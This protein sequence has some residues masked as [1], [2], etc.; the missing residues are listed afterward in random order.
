MVGFLHHQPRNQKGN[1]Q[2][3]LILHFKWRFDE[4]RNQSQPRQYRLFKASPKFIAGVEDAVCILEVEEGRVGSFAISYWSI[5][6]P[7]F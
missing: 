2:P 3:F 4:K 1:K 6:R 7:L 5:H